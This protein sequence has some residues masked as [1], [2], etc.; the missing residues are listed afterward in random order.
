LDTSRI[1]VSNASS[2]ELAET[3]DNE[4]NAYPK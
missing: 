4:A 1:P 2:G 3:P